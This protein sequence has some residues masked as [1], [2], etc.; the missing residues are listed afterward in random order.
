MLYNIKKILKNPYTLSIISKAFGV[1]V[2]LLFTIFQSRY[3]GAE[4]RGQVATVNSIVSITSIVF[5]FGI[6]DA[7]PYYKRNSNIDIMPIFMK[8]ALLLLAVYSFISLFSVWLFDLS[9]KYIAV[10]IITP[11]MTYDAIVSYI[12]LI[13]VPNKRSITDIAILFL[14]LVFLILLW[15]FAPPSFIVGVFLIAAKDVVKAILFTVW[16]RKRIFVHSES[17]RVWLPKLVKFG[18]FPMLSILMTTLNYRLDVV[19]LD[20]RVEDAAIGVYSVGVLLAE[21]IWMIPDAMKGVM[22][23]NISKG[24]DARETAYVIR[25][26]N[27]VSLLIVITIIVLGKPFLDIAFGSEYSGSYQ[28]TLILLAGVFSMIYYKMIASYNIAMGKQVISFW[29]LAIGVVINIIANLVLIPKLGIYGAGLASVISYAI[30]S[31]LFIIYF[32]K[33]TKI[34]F[35]SMI[36]MNKE[37]YKYLKSKLKKKKPEE[38]N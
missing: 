18:F 3:L 14:E 17:L 4:I 12:T 32:C 28:V 24:K 26:C 16:W 9:P 33:E 2:G 11:L 6:Y 27:T 30:C 5:G 10:F 21:R 35:L 36:V 20:G 22:V 1:I 15:V 34:S 19:M 13:E 37:D 7:Y 23:S 38:Q 8:I 29:L 25:I 31:S